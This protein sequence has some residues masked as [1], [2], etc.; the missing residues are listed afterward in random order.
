[1]LAVTPEVRS[2]RTEQ[3]IASDLNPMIAV[4]IVSMVRGWGLDVGTAAAGRA[5]RKVRKV[6]RSRKSKLQ[7]AFAT[8][9]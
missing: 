7:R 3:R 5:S 8:V 6:S 2:A 9:T 4:L 1:V